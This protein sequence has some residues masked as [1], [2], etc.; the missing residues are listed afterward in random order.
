[1]T[2][3]GD[4][5]LLYSIGGVQ[6]DAI[7]YSDEALEAL[8]KGQKDFAILR[9]NRV[10]DAGK[11]YKFLNAVG[12]YRPQIAKVEGKNFAAAAGKEGVGGEYRI[13]RNN[14]DATN[15]D[16]YHKNVDD[17]FSDYYGPGIESHP[18]EWD[19]ICKDVE[20]LGGEVDV[21]DRIDMA[22][23]P[24]RPGEPG[25]IIINKDA[26]IYALRHEYQHFLDD[27]EAGWPG[28]A[29]NYKD[30]R[31]RILR[32]EK[33]YLLEIREADALGL[34]D[35]ARQLWENYLNERKYILGM[36]GPFR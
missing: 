2:K 6:F 12:E 28:A 25:K 32:E 8:V 36:Y 10:G 7:K 1:M 30:Y 16:T 35:V 21:R 27:Y 24:K 9:V 19:N 3:T 18:K 29:A 13:A 14:V 34:N 5:I 23:Q 31:T 20:R 4:D 22:Y 33:A 26:S 17:P 15:F 11:N